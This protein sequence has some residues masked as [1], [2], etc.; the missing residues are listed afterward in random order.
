LVSYLYKPASGGCNNTGWTGIA[1][2]DGGFNGAFGKFPI[3]IL[4]A[5]VQY[6]FVLDN[7][8]TDESIQAFKIRKANVITPSVTGECLPVVPLR[9]YIHANIPGEH[10]VID[11]AGNLVAS[12][13]F[14][15]VNVGLAYMNMG[16]F[17][18]SGTVRRDNYNRE[19]LDRNF[20]FEDSWFYSGNG[21]LKIKLFFANSELQ[22]LVNEPNDGIADV[23]ALGDLNVSIDY[24]C[25]GVLSNSGY[26]PEVITRG[27]LDANT[28]YV[29]FKTENSGSFF[30]HGGSGQ[31]N[32]AAYPNYTQSFDSSYLVN[33]WSQLKIS[34]DGPITTETSKTNPLIVPTGDPRFIFFDA[35]NFPSN[36]ETR[37]ISIPVVTSGIP[38][39]AVEFS[40][41][42]SHIL[43]YT[44]VAEGVQVEYSLNGTTWISGGTFIPRHDATLAA[45]TTKWNR[46][47]IILPAGA[48]N[49]PY[50]YVGFKFR[51]RGGS[52]CA[53]DQVSILVTPPCSSI[54]T[55]LATTSISQTSV[56]FSWTLV[57]GAVKYEYYVSPDPRLPDYGN[58]TTS[59]NASSVDL[60]A[61]KTYYIHVRPFCSSTN[62]GSWTTIK[63]K[64]AGICAGENITF[65]AG[66][67]QANQVYQW[68]VNTGSGWT[69]ISNGAVYSGVTT[70]ALTLTAVPGNYEGYIYRMR[71][72]FVPSGVF[73]FTDPYSF[74]M[75]NTWTGNGNGQWSNP[76]NWTCGV[77]DQYTVVYIPF[78]TTNSPVVSTN[79]TC[80][81]LIVEP[82]A[83]VNVTGT[84]KL[85]VTGS[86]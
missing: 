53:L 11:T 85:T 80:K 52:H 76:L 72:T 74:N 2:A 78:G 30:L 18:G 69:N 26:I 24:G 16:Y 70:T 39:V 62:Q 42:N 38:S 47:K 56:N 17:V 13:D 7:S 15:E 8:S 77:P 4:N 23:T 59:L 45:G 84:A 48:G 14:S 82:G 37:L 68:Q 6:L 5:G 19:Y 44:D 25:Y 29:S 9:Q 63:F 43:P 75:R 1:G 73:Y 66:S 32:E 33:S 81:N 60:D 12:L 54:L 67:P 34:G 71:Y 27:V 65:N 35:R 51:S 86:Q 22:K 58:E 40:W 64:T 3:G 10:F 20:S 50:I 28:S 36:T 31:L 57:P 55:G 49:Q 41:L 46:K 21:K 61:G 79:A 83:V